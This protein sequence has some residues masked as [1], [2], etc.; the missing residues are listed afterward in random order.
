VRS[1]SVAFLGSAFACLGIAACA[2]RYEKQAQL[3]PDP[4]ET[5]PEWAFD[6]PYYY[7]ASSDALPR[8]ASP[9]AADYPTHYYVN[10][11]VFPIE[12]PDNEVA[13]DRAPRIAVWWTSTDGCLWSRA[14]YFGLGQSQFQF[15]GGDDAVYG[16]RF[17][18]PGIRE[19]LTECTVPHR[20]YHLDTAAP[21][22]CIR[23][24]PRRPIY[25]PDE[26]L[27]VSWDVT[28]RN[29]DPQ[30]VRLS[31]CWSWENPDMVELRR[32]ADGNLP[33][34]D[35]P[36]PPAT[37]LWRPLKADCAGSDA[38]TFTIPAQAAGETFQFQVRAKDRA[39]NYGAGYS[40]PILV[41]GITSWPTQHAA[42]SQPA[43][44]A[45]VASAGHP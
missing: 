36:A 41:N 20:V 13:I 10:S 21:K 5:L 26:S 8:P 45:S 29:L 4:A 24:E 30:S 23:L 6:A 19:S 25:N 11:R 27:T 22:I 9:P 14:G 39:G 42:S 17:V 2:P 28:D 40:C 32:P 1:C 38:T 31:I 44:A 43:G 7:R 12:R 37:R 34:R 16:I 15:V 18:G 35:T 33:P 3:P